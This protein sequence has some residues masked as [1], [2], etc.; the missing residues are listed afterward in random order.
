MEW[1]CH[2]SVTGY[3]V[4]SCLF[5]GCLFCICL[6]WMTSFPS[7]SR[8][9][10]GWT[11]RACM[12][13]WP[14]AFKICPHP[15]ILCIP[16][17]EAGFV[18]THTSANQ[19]GCVHTLTDYSITPFPILPFSHSFSPSVCSAAHTPLLLSCLLNPSIFTHYSC[20]I[21]AGT[22]WCLLS[23]LSTYFPPLFH[24]SQI[25][26]PLS[27]SVIDSWEVPKLVESTVADAAKMTAGT[28]GT[29]CFFFSSLAIHPPFMQHTPRR[30]PY[31][32][33]VP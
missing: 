32:L 28:A 4:R 17:A 31:T 26:S 22:L 8:S 25:L 20:L 30:L 29:P 21:H 13:T 23:C 5:V 19:Y 33:S 1:M 9:V 15:S 12:A 10:W 24:P 14:C 7:E 6:I 3:R 18:S 11:S 2:S 27:L 16:S